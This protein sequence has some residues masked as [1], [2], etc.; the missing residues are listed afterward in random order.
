[1]LR[2]KDQM[3]EGTLGYL[4]SPTPP[5]V[6]TFTHTLDGVIQSPFPETSVAVRV[7]M[8]ITA[9]IRK[10]MKIKYL[11]EWEIPPFDLNRPI[12]FDTE[13]CIPATT[14]SKK[15][16]LAL[17]G[18][19]RLMQ[20]AQDGIAYMYDCFFMD[21]EEIKSYFIDAHL[22]AHNAVY[23]FSCPDL[24]GWLPKEID[25][26]L[27]MMKHAVPDLK[28]FSLATALEHFVI[29]V[30]GEEGAS[31]WS[32][33]VLTEE[34]LNYAGLDV[35]YLEQLYDNINH[36]REDF[37]TY[38]L[39]MINLR[40]SLSYQLNGFPVRESNRLLIIDEVIVKQFDY[41]MRLPEGLNVNSPKQVCAF[42]GVESS[43]AAVLSDLAL[44]GNKDAHNVLMLRKYTKQLSTLV[45]KYS[46]PRIYG[47]FK[48][49]GAASGRWTCSGNGQTKASQNLQQIPRDLKTVFGFEDNNDLYLVDADYTAL[50]IH[51]AACIMEE[52]KMI[53]IMHAGGDL[54]TTTAIGVYNKE[55]EDITK[56]ERQ[57]GKGLN[58]SL[59]Y[60]AG[61]TVAQI[62]IAQMAGILLPL[63]EVE[64]LR[65]KWLNTYPNIKAF[66]AK[67]GTLIRGLSGVIVY[68]PMRRPI[69]AKSYTESINVPCQGAGAETTKIAMDLLYKKIPDAKIVNTVH[70]SITLEVEGFEEAKR[71]AKILKWCLDKSWEVMSKYM[72]Y[73][74]LRM[75]NE[76][77]VNKVYEGKKLWSTNDET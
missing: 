10:I 7:L 76:A 66:H 72:P 37:Q 52:T 70:D 44:H 75:N 51:T 9:P 16:S 27:D 41:E 71:Q 17:Y 55:A 34:Q 47:I 5:G 4:S 43:A 50:E 77:T 1:M 67:R 68:T 35:L 11:K 21:M 59:M 53:D 32:Q 57:I 26:T 28:S 14:K 25:C 74:E 69:W 20:F 38:R 33:I 62:F 48:P 45:D 19:T 6:Q 49:F 46:F 22:Y 3:P 39:D 23:D 29:G 73:K 31:D 42:L 61:A 54:H 24:Y 64:T 58:F 13:T 18:D 65:K 15:K 40:H 8:P 63:S 60:G 56:Q 30:K 12:A 36:V 2:V